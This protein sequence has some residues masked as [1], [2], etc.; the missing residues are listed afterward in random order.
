[1]NYLVTPI[2][3][4]VKISYAG[5]YEVGTVVEV[6]GDVRFV[7]CYTSDSFVKQFVRLSCG[8][9]AH[10]LVWPIDKGLCVTRIIGKFETDSVY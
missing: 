4:V 9:N 7:V 2:K 8:G 1:M 10:L 6:D 3:E 5:S